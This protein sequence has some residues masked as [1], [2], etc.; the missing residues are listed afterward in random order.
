MK[1]LLLPSLLAALTA[2]A[3]TVPAPAPA[4]P[5]A[6]PPA[7]KPLPRVQEDRLAQLVHLF[8]RAR[9]LQE[10]PPTQRFWV[11][12]NDQPANPWNT[13][14][15][16][17]MTWKLRDVKEKACLV[18][19][20]EASNAYEGDTALD[21]SLPILV[22]R[23]DGLKAPPGVDPRDFYAGWSGGEI[24]LT[25]PVPG[26]ELSSREIADALAVQEFGEGWRMAEFHDTSSGGWAWWAYWGPAPDRYQ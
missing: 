18:G 25:R 5:E 13:R 1:R 23:R 20:D 15:G 8:V 6:R 14:T 22:I 12:I 11:F 16:K 9:E 3:P 19:T 17:A 26:R 10:K 7:A 24:R 4:A 21:Q 2:C